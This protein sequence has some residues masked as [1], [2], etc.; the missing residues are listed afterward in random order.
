MSW[1][2]GKS[3]FVLAILAVIA[4]SLAVVARNW[5]CRQSRWEERAERRKTQSF[6]SILDFPTGASIMV[7]LGRGDRRSLCVYLD[8]V[9]APAKGEPLHEE[10]KTHLSQIVGAHFLVEVSEQADG[11]PLRPGDIIGRVFGETS[12]DAAIEQL[13]AGLVVCDA[14]A[15]SKY[16]AV[17]KA[18]KQA[19]LGLWA[20]RK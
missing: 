2:M 19:K 10:S 5:S 17:E 3:T 8:Y 12:A 1:M 20:G 6:D 15:P 4:V 7:G 16:R 18:A 14:D 13:R 11:K 9:H